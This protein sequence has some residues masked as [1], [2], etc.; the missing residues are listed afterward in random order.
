MPGTSSEFV[1]TA[2]VLYDGECSFCTRWV[3]FWSGALRRRN[4]E[5]AALQ[6]PW[7]EQRLRLS[8]EQI[9]Y[10]IRLLTADGDLISGANVYLYVW[11]RIWWAWPLYAVFSRPGCNKLIHLGYRWFARNRHCVSQVCRIRR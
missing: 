5:T 10:D 7:V 8:E 9:L 11:R 1:R 3:S 6:E 4:I 2:C